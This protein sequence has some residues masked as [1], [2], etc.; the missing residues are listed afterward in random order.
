MLNHRKFTDAYLD[1][2]TVTHI[3]KPHKPT[4]QTKPGKECVCPTAPL[5]DLWATE[6]N[7]E[8]ISAHQPSIMTSEQYRIADLFLKIIADNGGQIN[9]DQYAPKLSQDGAIHKDFFIVRHQLINFEIIKFVPNSEEYRIMFSTNGRVAQTVGL[10]M[11]L[12]ADTVISE[13]LDNK[14]SAITWPQICLELDI[15]RDSK[16]FVLQKIVDSKK[17]ILTEISRDRITIQN[18]KNTI[19]SKTATLKAKIEINANNLHMGDNESGQKKT[20]K[21][22]NENSSFVN[23]DRIKELRSLEQNKFDF[24]KLIAYCEEANIC[25]QNE[26]YLSVAMLTRAI[27]DHI[28]PV[29][30]MTNFQNVYGQY[31]SKS[32]K[33][34]MTHLDKSL[35]KIADSFLHSHVRNKEILPNNTQVNFSQALDVLLSEICRKMK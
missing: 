7:N 23:V 35:R 16:D 25:Y 22:T 30:D 34:Q 14:K 1:Q 6:N 27:I 24:C 8:G 11:F 15:S 13:Y 26:C 10:K 17:F 21:N 32:F 18:N 5:T 2:H 28:P 9:T 12:E 20:K 33:E 29:F 4:L 19:P 3:A 31:G